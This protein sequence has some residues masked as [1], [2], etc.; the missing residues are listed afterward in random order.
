M[1]PRY[2]NFGFRVA[3]ILPKMVD[4]AIFQVGSI[5]NM[6]E[7]CLVGLYTNFHNFS[8]MCKFNTLWSPTIM[9]YAEGMIVIMSYYY[10]VSQILWTLTQYSSCL[11]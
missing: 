2:D 1:L 10:C 5:K 7:Y 9:L 11:G 4:P 3:A 6:R 8:Q